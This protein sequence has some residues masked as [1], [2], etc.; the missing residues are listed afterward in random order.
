MET[1]VKIEKVDQK[2]TL[3]FL[4]SLVRMRMKLKEDNK[5]EGSF[6]A[7]KLFNVWLSV[8]K[9]NCTEQGAK[10]M[11]YRYHDEFLALMGGKTHN[12]HLEHQFKAKKL[13]LLNRD[14]IK[15]C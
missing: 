8:W 6:E 3:T 14:S 2:P 12:S 15:I 5:K 1:V 11:I 7:A 13:G 10:R 9:E 4:K